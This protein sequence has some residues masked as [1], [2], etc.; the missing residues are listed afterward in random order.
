MT[1]DQLVNNFAIR[2]FR[3]VADE[4]YISARLAFRAALVAPSLWASQQAVE[5]YLKCILLLNRIHAADVYH[6][7]GK[8]L[9][10]IERS[11]KLVL[12]L[13]PL[14]RG[15]IEYLD[16]FGPYRYL[17]ISNVAF[18]QNLVRL[19][20][21]VWELR[22]FCTLS[23]EPRKIKLQGG[24]TAPKIRIPGG[25]LEEVMGD[26][27]NPAREPLLWSNAFFGKRQRRRVRIVGWVKA[28]NAPL[29]LNPELLEEI[30]K[31]VHLPKGIANGYR[32]HKSRGAR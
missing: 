5:K 29:F 14:T 19:D 31:Y 4:D 20:R 8:A 2:S 24:I 9:D 1:K 25:Y 12:D 21:A 26:I 13:T 16:E 10:A 32:A 6:N 18:G 23:D 11:G 30:L 28:T 27:K 17:E 15:F 3:D 7:L 22:R